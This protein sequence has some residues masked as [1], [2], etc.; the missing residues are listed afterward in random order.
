MVGVVAIHCDDSHLEVPN[1]DHS[2]SYTTS[3]KDRLTPK[4][5]QILDLNHP[6]RVGL[7]WHVLDHPFLLHFYLPGSLVLHRRSGFIFIG[8]CNL[9]SVLRM[10]FFSYLAGSRF[11]EASNLGPDELHWSLQVFQT[12]SLRVGI[13]MNWDR[14]Q[15]TA[16]FGRRRVLRLLRYKASVNTASKG[17]SQVVASAPSG[18]R[19]TA[20]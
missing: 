4:G 14:P 13:W 17:K 19:L 2:V 11:G 18:S 8:I 9:F 12:S 20:A 16:S 15:T 10:G 3:R 6:R 1:G 5:V 7:Q